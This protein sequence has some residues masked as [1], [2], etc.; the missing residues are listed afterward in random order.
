MLLCLLCRSFAMEVGAAVMLDGDFL[1][2]W[3]PGLGVCLVFAGE[4]ALKNE[5]IWFD[6][7]RSATYG[8]VHFAWL[9]QLLRARILYRWG[10]GIAFGA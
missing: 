6:L 9:P 4:T 1:Q 7:V 2:A 5:P 10:R 8:A 3:C